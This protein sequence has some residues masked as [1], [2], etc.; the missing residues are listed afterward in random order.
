MPKI[1]ATIEKK[2]WKEARKYCSKIYPL[3][4]EDYETLSKINPDLLIVRGDNVKPLIN[5]VNN[6]KIKVKLFDMSSDQTDV[7]NFM[8]NL[9][10]HFTDNHKEWSILIDY[11]DKHTDTQFF[12]WFV[13]SIFPVSQSL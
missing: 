9:D 8:V 10:A 5:K 4:R 13:S 7:I 2:H 3:T 12:Y 6:D 11:K 1:S